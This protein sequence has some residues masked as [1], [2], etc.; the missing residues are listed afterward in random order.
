[1]HFWCSISRDSIL[2]MCYMQ[3]WLILPVRLVQVSQA[4][5]FHGNCMVCYFIRRTSMRNI[6]ELMKENCF[7]VYDDCECGI[8][9]AYTEKVKREN[10]CCPTIQVPSQGALNVD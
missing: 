1:M 3:F 2:L 7:A 4:S 10:N 6:R 8:G 9:N 5:K